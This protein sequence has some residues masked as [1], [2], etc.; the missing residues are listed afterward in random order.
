M[1]QEVYRGIFVTQ[2]CQKNYFLR[3]Q[4]ICA[5]ESELASMVALNL[6]KIKNKPTRQD[7]TATLSVVMRL[8]F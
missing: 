2:N 3:G 6:K 7:G 5:V 1:L 4:K 8:Q